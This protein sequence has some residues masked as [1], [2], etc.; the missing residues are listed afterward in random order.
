MQACTARQ[1][2][3]DL[4]VVYALDQAH[5]FAGNVAMKP[6]WAK[7]VFSHKYARRK[8]DHVDIGTARH[9]GR[10]CQHGENAWIRVIKADRAYGVE[11]PQVVFVWSVVAVPGNDI[12]WGMVHGCTPQ[13]A[14]KFCDQF[15]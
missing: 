4:C 1:E 14:C 7:G 15:K 5:E 13:S 8:H 10:R 9:V 12:K 6:G 3:I 2:A 11:A